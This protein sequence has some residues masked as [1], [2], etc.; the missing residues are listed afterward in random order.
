MRQHLIFS[1]IKMIHVNHM[2]NPPTWQESHIHLR[3]IHVGASSQVHG[4]I[5]RKIKTETCKMTTM[6]WTLKTALKIVRAVLNKYTAFSTWYGIR[7]KVKFKKN[8][9]S[10]ST[11][12]YTCFS[13]LRQGGRGW[14]GVNKTKKKD[15]YTSKDGTDINI[16][17]D[18]KG[19]LRLRPRNIER[20]YG[21]S[22][23]HG[24]EKE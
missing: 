5:F 23:V 22:R 2:S 17:F 8:K 14:R 13:Y 1:P 15:N 19:D 7:T 21:K 12:Y 16:F 9:F 24:S 11:T 3:N 6:T 20:K 4:C 18:T 10:K